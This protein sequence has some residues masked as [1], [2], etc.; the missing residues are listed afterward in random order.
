MTKTCS[1][2]AL[3]GNNWAM[4]CRSPRNRDRNGDCIFWESKSL[5]DEIA[6]ESLSDAEP[7]VYTGKHIRVEKKKRKV[8]IIRVDRIEFAKGSKE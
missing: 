2:C 6:A 5:W 1:N 3:H 7:L 4:T 8:P